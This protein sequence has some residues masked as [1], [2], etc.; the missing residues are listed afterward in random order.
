[1]GSEGAGDGRHVHGVDGGVLGL[2]ERCDNLVADLAQEHDADDVREEEDDPQGV[3]V[4]RGVER[5]PDSAGDGREAHRPRDDA[6][7]GDAWIRRVWVWV[8]G[9]MKWEG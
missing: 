9:R 7:S 6:H 8:Q 2:G 5:S 3:G 1:M 4:G